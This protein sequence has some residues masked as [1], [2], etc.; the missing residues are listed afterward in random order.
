MPLISEN[1]Y[2]VPPLMHYLIAYRLAVED[3]NGPTLYFSTG[4]TRVYKESELQKLLL[5]P[6]VCGTFIHQICGLK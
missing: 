3:S 5:E 4:N 2:Q 1:F 6:E